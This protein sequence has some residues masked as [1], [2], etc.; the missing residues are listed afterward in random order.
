MTVDFSGIPA[1]EVQGFDD[2]N[3]PAGLVFDF[4]IQFSQPVPGSGTAVPGLVFHPEPPD[5][6]QQGHYRIAAVFIAVQGFLYPLELRG[7]CDQG[8]E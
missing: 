1:V 3:G 6:Q 5:S 7:D 2:G 4:D 8:L